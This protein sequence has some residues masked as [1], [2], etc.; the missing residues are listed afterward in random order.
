ME[1]VMVN[2]WQYIL[3][4]C[5]LSVLM[6]VAFFVFAYLILSIFRKNAVR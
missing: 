4:A 5:A 6:F 3:G 1:S 2:L